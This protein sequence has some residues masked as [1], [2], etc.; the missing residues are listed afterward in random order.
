MTE[1]EKLIVKKY[2]LEKDISEC[3][4]DPEKVKEYPDEK[5]RAAV[6][7]NMSLEKIKNELD[8][9]EKQ[10]EKKHILDVLSSVQK[11]CA[12]NGYE[13]TDDMDLLMKAIRKNQHTRQM[14]F[15]L[16]LSDDAPEQWVKIFP[17]KKIYVAKYKMTFDFNDKF[18][19]EIVTNFENPKLFKPYIDEEHDLKKKN[20]DITALEIKDDG[21]Y[22]RVK[23]NDRGYQAIKGRVY[24][25]QSP[26]WGKRT[27]TEG[28]VYENVLW[29][30]SLTN[31]P[32][33]E[34][35]LPTLQDQFQLSKGEKME[36]E[37]KLIELKAR[38]K[39]TYKLAE[40]VE[41]TD[42]ALLDE[43]WSAIEELMAKYAAV[44]GEKEAVEKEK[45][46]AEEEVAAMKT[47]KLK[48]EAE[49]VVKLAI[50]RGQF[51]PKLFDLKVNQ[52]LKDKEAVT[53]ELSLI[54]EVKT[55]SLNLGSKKDDGFKLSNDDV[56]V[57]KAAG[58]DPEK[59]DD[60]KKYREINNL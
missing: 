21:L 2:G 35:E 59:S 14:S 53:T 52:Y 7:Y 47:E 24:S 1:N 12:K 25:Y 32:A 20:G 44:K 6:C 9:K 46:V 23:L 38:S 43:L 39:K 27:D 50:E 58:L 28:K 56:I 36:L 45:E 42:P 60:V 13:L 41:A 26:E 8:E 40:G 29:T 49:S 4:A 18:F 15:K 3:M 5:Q 48:A 10:E 22:G 16:E 57:M 51:S 37:K 33:M 54:P 31:T 55:G 34:G 11:L 17:K 30:V 19:Q